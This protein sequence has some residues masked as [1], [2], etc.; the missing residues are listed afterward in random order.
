[1]HPDTRYFH[2]ARAAQNQ[3]LDSLLE[4]GNGFIFSAPL[5]TGSTPA[6]RFQNGIKE[7]TVYAKVFRQIFE[8]SI[9]DNPQV[10]FTFMDLLV[11][12]DSDGVVDMT[13]ESIA[14]ITN[15]PIDWVRSSIEV[16][17]NPDPQSRN[18]T[19]S[20][21]RLKRLDDH[22]NWGWQIVNY[23]LYRNMRD[24]TA[25]KEYRR[26][27]MRNKRKEDR[28]QPVNRREQACITMNLSEPKQKQRKK[29]STEEEE[30]K[31]TVRSQEVARPSLEEVLAKAQFIG[32]AEWKARDWFEE[33]ECCGWIDYLHR[34]VV[35]W[36]S[37]LTRL[38]RKWESDG[39][40]ASPPAYRK[41]G[42]SSVMDLKTIIAA[43]EKSANELRN[44]HC[45]EG[46]LTN[47]W[48]NEDA[49]LK[50]MVLT[51]EIRELTARLAGMA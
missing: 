14:R 13:H 43:K 24:E 20:G 48:S 46:P 42:S 49:R 47:D 37:M 17:E 26:N 10:R 33:M 35:N 30:G 40:P 32:L 7:S 16:L 6:P 51:K 22:R 34:P 41:N 4:P 31:R 23:D 50:H 5:R 21:A 15:C 12:A 2:E 3:S 8:S 39:R 44:R 27:W 1:M 25:R 9:A 36:T 38:C 19:E 29:Q 28:E 45:I 18:P 11:L